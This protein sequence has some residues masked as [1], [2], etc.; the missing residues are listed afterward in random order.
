LADALDFLAQG[1]SIIPLRPGEK[2]PMIPWE[3][4]KTRKPTTEEV[5]RWFQDTDN[6]IAIVTG[7]ISGVAVVDCD[8]PEALDYAQT[9]FPSHQRTGTRN[10]L[11]LWFKHPGKVVRNSVNLHGIKMDIRGDGGYVVAPGS[12]HPSG[13]IYG[14]EGVWGPTSTLPVFPEA[15]LKA[16]APA[17][18][19]AAEIKKYLE[20]AAPA[21]AGDG[22]NQRTFQI[23]CR[24]VR[25][26]ALSVDETLDTLTEWNKTNQPPWSRAE[27][28]MIVRSALKSG[29]E[30]IGV[31]AE[32]ASQ[33][34]RAGLI[35]NRQ[36]KVLRH[37]NNAKTIFDH[38]ARF[39]GTI[40]L[41]VR[42]MTPVWRGEYV[43][44]SFSQEIYNEFCTHWG[45]IFPKEEVISNA[46]AT[47]YRNKFNPLEESIRAF[48][49]W[50]GVERIRRVIP[51][52][53]EAGDTELNQAMIK[54]FFIGAIARALHPGCKLDTALV[55]VGPQG[56]GKSTFFRVLGGDF[57]SDTPIDAESKDRFL[58]IHRA[59]ILE[60]AE[61]DGM[62]SVKTAHQIKGLLS[63]SKDDF[64]PPYGHK[65]E[66]V[67]R[68][69]I[70]VGTTN[71]KSHLMDATGSRR[72]W[73]MEISGKVDLKLLAE[74]REQLWAEA[75]SLESNNEPWWLTDAQDAMREAASEEYTVNDPWEESVVKSLERMG[76]NG[77][78][79]MSGVMV[80]EVLDTM[81]IPNAARNRSM[82][83]RIATIF[84][85]IGWAKRQATIRGCRSHYW[86]PI[87]EDRV[88][89]SA[90]TE[91]P[92]Y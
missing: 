34:W 86:F 68:S 38:D 72:F 78:S 90:T 89:V 12:R 58:A 3:E 81:D 27:L 59:W 77:K 60:L 10:G 61:L 65:L 84:R 49:P 62:T 54:C 74:W 13:F 88:P 45:T 80:K 35:T 47:A 67:P 31:L 17:S 20:G 91:T 15:I 6:N 9:N 50:D 22:G 33:E 43:E 18:G 25:G 66:T 69:C 36:G 1:Y 29:K 48:P 75:I 21:I 23:C 14:R 46:I 42:N 56:A 92:A 73:P 7:E 71:T 30:Q 11:H 76:E 55:I 52:I 57:F 40:R 44:E 5:T 39:A 41:D 83:M 8:S 79:L 16:E 70:M 63:S 82:D 51:E 37:P 85:K 24:L 32:A 19:V 4:F 64:R 2:K 26:Y 28:K 53:L 87:S